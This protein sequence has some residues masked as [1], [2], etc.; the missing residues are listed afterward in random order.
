MSD[1]ISRAGAIDQL[2]QS[3]NLLEAEER[4]KELPSAERT[5]E[6]IMKHPMRYDG[7]FL[8]CDVDEV[9]DTRIYHLYCSE[10]DTKMPYYERFPFCPYCGCRMK[11]EEY[12]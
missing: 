10:C 3:I 4:I 5:G 9:V 2:H 6:W 8:G 12:A 7:K 11:G 1:L